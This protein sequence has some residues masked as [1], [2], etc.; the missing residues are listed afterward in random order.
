[1]YRNSSSSILIYGIIHAESAHQP[2]VAHLYLAKEYP[3]NII[4]LVC[5]FLNHRDNL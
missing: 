2:P 3:Q 1:M 4:K 5:T